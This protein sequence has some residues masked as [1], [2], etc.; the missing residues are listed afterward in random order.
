MAAMRSPELRTESPTS[1]L[2]A[3]QAS[4]PSAVPEGPRGRLLAVEELVERLHGCPYPAR[5]LSLGQ[6]ERQV[7]M[8]EGGFELTAY[9]LEPIERPQ[10]ERH[11]E[12]DRS[13]R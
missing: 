1:V 3:P 13:S 9:G 6:R 12:Q 4:S 11:I 5:V 2:V 8:G 10:R 7:G